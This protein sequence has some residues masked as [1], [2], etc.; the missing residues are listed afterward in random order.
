MRRNTV[1]AE[2]FFFP[3]PACMLLHQLLEI[4]HPVIVPVDP[5]VLFVERT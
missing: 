2:L 4:D 3:D 1:F 5:F